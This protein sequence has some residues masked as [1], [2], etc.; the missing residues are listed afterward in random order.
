MHELDLPQDPFRRL[1]NANRRD[2]QVTRYRSFDQLLDYCSLSA[3]PV[4][5]LVLHVLG[6]A[7]PKRIELRPTAICAGL[8]ITEHLQDVNEDF[9]R[10]DGYI[11]PAGGSSRGSDASGDDLGAPAA[12]PSKTRCS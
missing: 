12:G 2:Q 5:E 1:I 6:A 11:L 3:A 9:A 7:T 10:R 8:Q 4:G